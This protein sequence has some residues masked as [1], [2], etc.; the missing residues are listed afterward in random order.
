VDGPIRA[1]QTDV[2]IGE[3]PPSVRPASARVLQFLGAN[4]GKTRL[5]YRGKNTNVFELSSV[6]PYFDSAECKVTP[7]TRDEVRAECPHAGHHL[8]RLELAMS[9]WRA[10]VG[11]Q[12]VGIQKVDDIF[13]E[14]NLPEGVS[15]LRFVY[16]PTGVRPAVWISTGTLVVI[17]AG[18]AWCSFSAAELS[19]RLQRE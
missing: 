19:S 9:G 8:V 15:T 5:V 14:I 3:A 10:F 17:F 16:A 12:E 1:G 13:Q 7:I 11:E 4:A 6:R 18:L 2:R